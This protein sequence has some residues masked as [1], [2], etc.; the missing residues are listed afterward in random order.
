MNYAF[1]RNSI[2][3]GQKISLGKRYIDVDMP[4]CDY[5]TMAKGFRCYGEEVT[6][7]NEIIP[8]LERAKN[9]SKPAVIDVKIKYDTPDITK[10]LFSM[11][12]A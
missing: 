8:A 9:S 6:D 4:G 2:K 12:S 7:P 10:F 1:A 11:G 3:S 5:G